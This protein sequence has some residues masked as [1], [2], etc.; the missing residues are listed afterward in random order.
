MNKKNTMIIKKFLLWG[1]S[2]LTIHCL[3][4]TAF[5]GCGEKTST[6]AK[7]AG[8]VMPR[9]KPKIPEYV[10][11][12]PPKKYTYKGNL[13]RDPLIP[14]G[15]AVYSGIDTAAEVMTS[16]KLATLQLKGIFRDKDIGIAIITDPNSGSSY[17]LKKG[18]VYNRKHQVVK[19]VAGVVRKN[20]MIT[21]FSDNIKID[22]KL[23]KPGEENKK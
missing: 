22:L 2:L 17:I 3:L 8:K 14:A 19:G 7:Q 12:P 23:K 10:P 6:Q 5:T 16:E 21:L 11:P 1:F 4:L 13:Y 20:N 15:A 9:P 18:K